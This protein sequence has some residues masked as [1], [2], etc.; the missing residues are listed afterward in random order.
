MSAPAFTPDARSVYVCADDPESRRL[1]CVGPGRSMTLQEPKTLFGY[2]FANKTLRGD[3]QGIGGGN[4]LRDNPMFVEGCVEVVAKS[5]RRIKVVGEA[6]AEPAGNKY[7][8][9]GWIETDGVT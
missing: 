4:M 7:H 5:D 9:A 1:I 2:P 8:I 3:V 6:R